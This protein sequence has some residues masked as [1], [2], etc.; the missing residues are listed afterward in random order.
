MKCYETDF[1]ST[2]LTPFRCIHKKGGNLMQYGYFDDAAREY[3]ELKQFWNVEPAIEGLL[4]TAFR[5][6]V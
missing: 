5:P 3:V 6:F 1:E 4:G 2:E